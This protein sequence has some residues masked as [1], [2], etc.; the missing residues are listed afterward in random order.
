MSWDG[1]LAS[2]KFIVDKSLRMER[3]HKPL[4]VSVLCCW[5]PA[6]FP[7]EYSIQLQSVGFKLFHLA[8]WS[9]Q[10]SSILINTL[11]MLKS[12]LQDCQLL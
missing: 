2:W 10:L 8:V 1:G 3:W 5:Y 9:L 4:S 11:K 12:E 7:Y 6:D